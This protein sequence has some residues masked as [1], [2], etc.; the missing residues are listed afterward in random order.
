MPASPRSLP[1]VSSLAC[2]A[3]RAFA[4]AGVALAVLTA[5]DPRVAELSIAKI[6]L[7]G[8]PA[9]ET[10]TALTQ[11]A[12]L[13]LGRGRRTAHDPSAAK[14]THTLHLGLARADEIDPTLWLGVRLRPVQKDGVEFRTYGVAGADASPASLTRAFDEAWQVIERQRDLEARGDEAVVQALVDPDR[15]V[16]G[17][18]IAR[19]GERRVGAAVSSLCERLKLGAEPEPE[20]LLRI[21]GAL[22]AIGDERAAG[23][24]I[25]ATKNRD[26]AFVVQVAFALG[27]VGGPTAEGYL[28]TLASGH[29]A[30]AVQRAA[31]DALRDLKTRGA[32]AK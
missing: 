23:P 5:C 29:P 25:D 12:M 20:L 4:G 16:R 14:P 15:R 8:I 30:E 19:A 18:A 6:S 21:V 31:A 13:T 32:R 7:E 11:H 17:F 27:A 2:K 1:I 9:G 3:A 10:A 28:V 26:P 24:L 22:A